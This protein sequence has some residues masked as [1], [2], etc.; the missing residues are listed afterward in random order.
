MTGPKGAS[1]PTRSRIATRSPC[2]SRCAMCWRIRRICRSGRPR[3]C[4]RDPFRI[5]SASPLPGGFRFTKARH[6]PAQPCQ[7]LGSE[8]GG[9]WFG[10]AVIAHWQICRAVSAPAPAMITRLPSRA[11]PSG[12]ASASR[13]LAPSRA[14]EAARW[15]DRVV[16]PEPPSLLRTET[17]IRFSVR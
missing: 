12:S 5:A 6:A 8:H 10:F 15:T 11:L 16:F 13:T 7:L 1:S 3:Q 17:I 14:N 4:V 9:R 2:L